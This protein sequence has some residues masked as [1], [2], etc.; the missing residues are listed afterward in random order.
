MNRLSRVTV[1][2]ILLVGCTVPP[3]LKQAVTGAQA[4][5]HGAELALPAFTPFL[6][7]AGLM[8]VNADLA[9]AEGLAAALPGIA[10]QALL[11]TNVQGVLNLISG[12]GNVVAAN[13]PQPPP[14]NIAEAIKEFQAAMK[15]AEAV[16]PL[17]A[18]FVG[19]KA[20]GATVPAVFRSTMTAD[21]A[22]VVLG[23][24]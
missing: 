23:V 13:L 18:P 17:V 14:P 21:Q 7:L 19:Q 15:I 4:I 6:T 2:L 1:A 24:R 10:D 11:A 9:K 20:G 5:V 16:A 8:Q 3:S 22:R 12:I